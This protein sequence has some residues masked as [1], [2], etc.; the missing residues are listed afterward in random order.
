MTASAT[1]MAA[2]EAWKLS[3]LAMHYAAPCPDDVMDH[4]VTSSEA[5]FQVLQAVPPASADDMLLKLYPIL[6][7]EFEPHRGDPPL[8]LSKSSC[9]EYEHAFREQ[10]NI[11]LAATSSQIAAAAAEPNARP[12]RNVA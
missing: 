3:E 1:M 9:R 12:E 2:F 10:L 6:L 11:D 5:A 8:R 4:L 7:R